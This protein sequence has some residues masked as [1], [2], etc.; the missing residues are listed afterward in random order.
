MSTA[1]EN[2]SYE[3]L[4]EASKKLE[5][6]NSKLESDKSILESKVSQLQFRLDQLNRLIFGARRER[7]V[8]NETHGQMS[9]PFE[10]E[11]KPAEEQEKETITYTRQ[12]KGHKNHPGR[13]PLPSHLPVEEIVLEPE[14]DITGMK[15][16]GNEVTDQLELVPAKLFIKRYIRPK[17]INPEDQE[18]L[19]HTGVIAPLP[20]FPIEKGIAGPGLLAQIMVDKYVDHLP[21]YRQVQRFARENVRIPAN[22]INGWQDSIFGLLSPLFEK[23]KQLVLGQGYLQI[24]ETPIRV[25]DKEVK[26]KCHQ[27]Y[28]WVYNSPIQNA[29]LYDYR[30]GR[31]REGPKEMLKGF[32]G[33]IQSDG[34]N[35]YDWFGK[36]K[37][38]T[39]VNCW[40]HARRYFEKAQD[41][42]RK[43][44]EHVLTEIQ[45]L[46]RIE[47]FCR[48][49]NHSPDERKA[50][51]LEHA[52]PILNSLGKWMAEKFKHT[53]PKSPMGEALQY[54]IARWDNLLAY[55]NDGYLEI[56]NNLVENA[57]RPNALGRKNYLF[58]GSHQGAQRAAMFYSFFGT[59][60]RNNIN[61]FEWLKDVLEKIPTY[62]ANKLHELLPQN[63]EK[64]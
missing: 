61:P 54:T 62:K 16:I 33:Y 32:R 20:V 12:K 29:V 42:D 27:G 51:R 6:D 5:S 53:L 34:Y 10:V 7:F 13:I 60:K 46:Y 24:D 44:S 21:I 23:Q 3:Q 18:T 56:D 64:H 63:W 50:I 37:E 41:Y 4:L 58:A 36:K 11:E 48:N 40:A 55:L 45:Q 22:T 30:K 19:T 39:L 59:C 43:A 35:V 49:V 25:L 17:Y 28:Y 2:M 15:Y 8:S 26:G 57:I 9:L 38:I 52:L 31:G 1:L 14:E 47:R